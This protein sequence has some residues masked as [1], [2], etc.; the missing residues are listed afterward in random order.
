MTITINGE[1]LDFTLEH[2]KTAGDVAV[3]LASWLEASGML[4][5]GLSLDEESVIMT[6]EQWRS[7]GIDGISAM[8][9]EAV[10]VREGRLR[11]FETARDY[12]VLM[13]NA[14]AG[15]NTASLTELSDGFE[16]VKRILPNLLGERE[17]PV[18]TA[19]L[20]NGLN[21]AGFP[22]D[23]PDFAAIT[24]ESGRIAGL[25]ESRRREI[26]NPAEEAASA[27]AALSA[28]ADRLDDVAVNLQTGKDR[29]AM[30]TIILLTELLQTLMRSLSWMDQDSDRRK[31][32]DE[33]TA[34]LEELEEALKVSDTV[35]IGDLLEYEIKPRLQDLPEN[36]GFSGENAS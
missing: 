32:V 15:E 30:E 17:A 2:E 29:P 3:A 8:N 34:I 11:Q 20:E 13:N 12:F 35:L 27:S 5:A 24:N 1:L 28:M 21:R 31:P 18:F 36:L 7:R 25:L 22:G 6:E 33:L 23:S 26:A 16:D 14:A 10:S 19:A 9:V 4:I